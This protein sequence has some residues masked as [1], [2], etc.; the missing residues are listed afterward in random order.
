[1]PTDEEKRFVL[2]VEENV[3][4]DTS[5]DSLTFDQIAE[6]ADKEFATLDIDGDYVK[7]TTW[8]IA[9]FKNKHVGKEDDYQPL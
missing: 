6:V 3:I 1:M 2:W 5:M 4:K 7:S 9:A 8:Q